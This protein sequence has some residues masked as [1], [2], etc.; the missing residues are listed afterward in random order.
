MKLGGKNAPGGE[1]RKCQALRVMKNGVN[2][3]RGVRGDR[4]SS[5]GTV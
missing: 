5:Y 4:A 2:T 1:D 3:S